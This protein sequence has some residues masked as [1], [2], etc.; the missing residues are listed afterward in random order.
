ML[1]AARV[2]PLLP[3]GAINV[4][5]ALTTIR[6]SLFLSATGVGK[7]P[8]IALEALVSHD[9]L[10]FGDHNARLALVLISLALLGMFWK[11]GKQK[12]SSER[13]GPDNQIHS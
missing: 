12:P 5:G 10:H 1:V 3:S 2:A 4:I 11:I 6:L 8:S 13:T 9:L 7:I